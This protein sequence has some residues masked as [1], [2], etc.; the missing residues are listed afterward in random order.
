MERF[1]AEMTNLPESL[2]NDEMATGKLPTSSGND[3]SESYV[4]ADN[5]PIGDS[6]KLNPQLDLE[7][8]KPELLHEQVALNNWKNCELLLSNGYSWNTLI[9]NKSIGDVALECKHFELYEKLK[10]FGIR[11]EY[12][13]KAVGQRVIEDGT[14]TSDTLT[15]ANQ[16]YLKRKLT[17]SQDGNLLLDSKNNAVMMGWERPIMHKSVQILNVRGR[18][19]LNVGF[20]LGII[21]TLLQNE[22]PSSHTIIEAHP[23]V[24]EY[25]LKNGWEKKAKILFGRWQDHLDN[26]EQYDCVYFDTFGEYYDDLFDFHQVIVNHLSFDGIYSFFNGLGGTNQFFHDVYCDICVMDLQEM[27]L[28]C[29]FIELQVNELGDE[30]WTNTKR[31]YW[32][33]PIYRLPVVTFEG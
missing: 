10:L 17:F 31:P 11:V 20:G 30:V 33:L 16:E 5:A 8:R 18:R 24:Y 3:D 23:D 32:S 15:A 12:I 26:L 1:F 7:N 25:M 4:Y 28:N 2:G 27:G 9:N 14:L 22:L 6:L 29:E 13:L 19:V 21:D